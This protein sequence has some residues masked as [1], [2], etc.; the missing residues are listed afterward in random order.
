MIL[1]FEFTDPDQVP[2]DLDWDPD[3]SNLAFDNLIDIRT[4]RIRTIQLLSNL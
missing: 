3:Q 2:T 1:Y 4:I